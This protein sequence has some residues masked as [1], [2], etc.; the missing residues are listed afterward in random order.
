[1]RVHGPSKRDEYRRVSGRGGKF[2]PIEA[3][4]GD[5]LPATGTRHSLD[6]KHPKLVAPGEKVSKHGW[7]RLSRS[8]N[9]VLSR[10]PSDLSVLEE[11]DVCGLA[12]FQTRSDP[13]N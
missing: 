10:T 11:I 6:A 2:V 5:P 4:G 1:K 8:K 3:F 7:D 12:V 13:G 9:D